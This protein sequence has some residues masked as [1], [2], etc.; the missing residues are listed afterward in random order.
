ME[1]SGRNRWQPVA[2]GTA[3]KTAQRG[4]NRCRRLRPVAAEMVRSIPAALVAATVAKGECRRRLVDAGIPL[5][6]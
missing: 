2:N 4:E 1:Q 3:A 6:L 5:V